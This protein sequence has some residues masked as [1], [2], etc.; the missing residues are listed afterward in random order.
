MTLR[1]LIYLHMGYQFMSWV[2]ELVLLKSY[3]LRSTDLGLFLDHVLPTLSLGYMPES[4]D[5]EMIPCGPTPQV[6]VKVRGEL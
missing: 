5:L 2:T 1:R 6:P 4:P 3:G